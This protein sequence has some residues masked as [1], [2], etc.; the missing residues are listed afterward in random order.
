MQQ[1]KFN[2]IPIRFKPIEVYRIRL[3]V[4]GDPKVDCIVNVEGFGNKGKKRKGSYNSD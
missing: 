3:Y 1:S 2:A 4:F